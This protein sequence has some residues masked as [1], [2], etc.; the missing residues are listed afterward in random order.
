[1]ASLAAPRPLEWPELPLPATVLMMLVFVI[2][3]RLWSGN[4]FEVLIQCEWN[5][6]PA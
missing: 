3:K 1:M 2:R 5:G 6:R 4:Y